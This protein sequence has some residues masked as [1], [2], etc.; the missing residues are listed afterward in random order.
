MKKLLLSLTAFV[1]VLTAS[2]DEA[3]GWNASFEPVSD[4]TE[5]KGVHVTTADGAVYV[6]TTYNKA[7]TFAGKEI[8]DPEGLTSAA[9]VKYDATGKEQWAVS[10]EGNAVVYALDADADGTLYA[11]GNFMDMVKYTGADGTSAEMTSET[12]YSA[13]VAK[14][15]ADGKFQ[16]VKT[17]TPAVDATVAAAVGDPWGMGVEE[18]LYTMW[19]PIYVAPNK[20]QVDGDKVY[21]SAKYMGDVAAL[22]WEGSYIDM[23]GLMYS[24]NYS[25]GVFSLNKADLTG[26]ASVA[27]VQMTGI[28]ADT[29]Y[30]PEALTFAAENGTVYVGFI[31]F[32]KLTLTSAAGAENFSFAAAEDGSAMEHAFVLATIGATTSTKVYNAEAHG[33]LAVPY[34]LFMDVAG[35]NLIIGGTFHGQLPLDTQKT[36]GELKTDLFMAS[37]KKADG[38]VNNTFVAGKEIEAASMSVTGDKANVASTAAELYQID[39]ATG[40]A[41]TIATQQVI[42]CA[43]AATTVYAEKTKVCINST[44]EAITGIQQVLRPT[45]QADGL[46]YNL[47]G[48]PVGDNYKGIVIRNGKKYMVK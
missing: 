34:N 2:A 11:A 7:F 3:K 18:P 12:V 4:S 19:D 43:D 37:V 17:I 48:Q 10:M 27:N 31:G 5:L 33:Q 22:G 47:A 6:S 35:D 30:Y 38:T 23:F 14:I 45:V 20:I 29:Q 44:V 41:T 40:S 8:A 26:E 13:F 46:I 25:M 15:S 42:L 24:D 21:V 16:A 32:Q 28:T 36:A 39:L 1:A 9:I